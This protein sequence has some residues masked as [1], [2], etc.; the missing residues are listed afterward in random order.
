MIRSPLG[1]QASRVLQSPSGQRG[2]QV[3]ERL[4]CQHTLQRPPLQHRCIAADPDRHRLRQA[5]AQ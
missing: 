5:F 3:M 1:P 2:H 4:Q